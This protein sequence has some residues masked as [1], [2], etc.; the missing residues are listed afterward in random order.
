M[1]INCLLVTC[2][3]ATTTALEDDESDS[4]SVEILRTL[5]AN[6][7]EGNKQVDPSLEE[8]N[9]RRKASINLIAS[10]E[11]HMGQLPPPTDKHVTISP[12]VKPESREP[13]ESEHNVN[14]RSTAC[15]LGITI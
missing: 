13:D 11:I 6:F 2:K 1:L 7:N 5:T 14:S 4:S 12:I 9:T 15:A 10:G 3:V 8:L